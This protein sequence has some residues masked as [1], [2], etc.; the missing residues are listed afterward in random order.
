MECSSTHGSRGFAECRASVGT[1]VANG[2]STSRNVAFT[3]I[4]C[5]AAFGLAEG[6]F[7]GI[8]MGAAGMR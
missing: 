4:E 7:P 6:R 8:Q 1:I 2:N 3:A 5:A